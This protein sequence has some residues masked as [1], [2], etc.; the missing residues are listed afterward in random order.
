MSQPLASKYGMH[1]L[2]LAP[3]SEPGSGASNGAI[4]GDVHKLLDPDNPMLWLLGIGAATLGLVAASTS[5][6]VG[7]VRG[8]V[9]VGKG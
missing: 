6:R 2:T 4:S 7:P 1:S 8:S 3:M 9:T 5:L